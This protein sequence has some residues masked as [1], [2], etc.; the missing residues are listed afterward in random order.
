MPE[1]TEQLLHF[2]N[3]GLHLMGPKR[4]APLTALRRAVG[5]HDTNT[6]AIRSRRG[7]TTL[8]SLSGVHSLG[9]LNT[10]RFQG[11]G[12]TLY[13]DG[14]ALVTGLSG[15]YLALPKSPPAPGLPDYLFVTGGGLS[16]KILSS[17]TV[18]NWG[19]APPANGLT[20]GAGGGAV[21]L[22]GRYWFHTTFMNTVTGNRSNSEPTQAE[23]L[24]FSGTTLSLT[25]IPVS[26]D[27]Q[28]GRREI[29]RTVGDGGVFLYDQA[30]NDNT[31][32]VLADTTLDAIPVGGSYAT[33]ALQPIELPL[34]NAFPD[35]TYTDA[36]IDQLTSFWISGED[37][38]K[39]RLYYSPVGRPEGVR[40]FVTVTN[41]NDA[42]Q[43]II[44]WNG[45][46]VFTIKGV[47]KIDGADPYA[48]RLITGV[49]GVPVA[50]RRTVT[51]SPYGIF[52]QAA[53]GL[54][55]FDGARSEL[56]YFDRI[57]SLFRGETLDDFP[58][59]EGVYAEFA[60]NQYFISN[61]SRTL[62]INYITGLIRELGVG[63]TSLYYEED[64]RFL[65][66]ATSAAVVI[67]EDEAANPFQT[68]DLETGSLVL[69]VGQD[70]VV[71]RL[72]I[73]GQFAGQVVTPAILINEVEQVLPPFVMDNDRVEYAIGLPARSVSVRLQATLTQPIVVEQIEVD[74]Y[75]SKGGV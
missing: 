50:Q 16:R 6:G 43:R 36:I 34:D 38:K 23:Q 48:R 57:G 73:K 3:T 51:P 49:P 18:Q 29:W 72:R 47:Y 60:R 13:R 53:D 54:R 12:G 28:V 2:P 70:A 42:L 52:Y 21:V 74:I 44:A 5:L 11:A 45:R 55:L 1:R 26:T 22:V 66:G 69:P 9:R 68:F 15:A 7:E 8:Q 19:I 40:G 56:I 58:A 35:Q 59:F 33:N 46:Y 31:T 27:P 10:T 41:D 17:G 4:A 30:I 32:T 65:L 37:G 24:G 75:E 14:V 25:N 67:L 63:L 71:K 39:G 64:T 20:V 62:A 61:G